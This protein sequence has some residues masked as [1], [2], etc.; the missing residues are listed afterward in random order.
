MLRIHLGC[1]P[2]A[3]AGWVNVDV[4]SYPG[5]DRVLDVRNGL[6]FEDA[7]LIFAEHFLEHFSLDEATAL[8]GECRRVLLPDG[9][10]RLSTPNLDWVWITS[11]PTRWVEQSATRAT[12]DADAWKHDEQAARD[13]VVM[14][15]AFRAWGHKF[16]WNMGML[17]EAL[18]RAGFNTVKWCQYGESEHPELRGLERH[19]RYDDSP[20]LPH[21]L[22]AEASGQATPRSADEL[23]PVLE[24]YR[25]DVNVD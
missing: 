1:G 25:R 3:M 10:L 19:E 2:N 20:E 21:L 13:C 5:V 6:P 15:R 14:N 16:L 8:L 4:K 23:E 7:T 22:I 18:R 9:V 11:Y 24:Q 12:I 17:T